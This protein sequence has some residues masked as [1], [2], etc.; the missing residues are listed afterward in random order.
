MVHNNYAKNQEFNQWHA[1]LIHVMRK[2]T[3]GYEKR[4]HFDIKEMT[5][6]N[7]EVK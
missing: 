7:Q 4:M 1:S 6:K 2:V 3:R 5:V